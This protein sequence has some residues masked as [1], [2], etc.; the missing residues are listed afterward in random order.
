MNN[1]KIFVSYKYADSNVQYF[2]GGN[3]P[4][5]YVNYLEENHVSGNDIFKGERDNE[6]LA[7][8]KDETIRTHLKDKIRDSSVTIVLISPNMLDLLKNEKDQWIPWEISYSLKKL[9]GKGEN[10]IVAVVLPD[11]NGSYN[12]FINYYTETLTNYESCNFRSLSLNRTFKIIQSNSF[13]K[14]KS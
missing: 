11:F 12:Y 10:G 8:F 9:D 6:S 1:R 7:E 5:Y 3:T 2:N 13:N 4:R 14:K